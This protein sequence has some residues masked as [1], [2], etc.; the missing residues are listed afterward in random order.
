MQKL[1][2]ADSKLHKIILESIE[3][4]IQESEQEDVDGIDI[5]SIDIETLKDAYIDLRLVPSVTVYGDI[6]SDIPT[7]NEAI[8]DIQTPDTVV[9]TIRKKYQ[10][11][12]QFVAKVEVYNKIYIYI[13]TACIGINDKIIEQDMQKMGYFLGHRKQPQNVGGMLFQVLQFEPTSQMQNDETKNIKAQYD[14][15]YHW[16]PEYHLNS[17]LQNGLIPNHQNKMFDYPHRIYLMKGDSNVNVMKQL[18]QQ[19]CIV[20][21]DSRN[22]GV[23]ALLRVGLKDI[24]EDIHFYYDSNAEIGI[25][26]EQAIPKNHIELVGMY[27]FKIK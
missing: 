20:N 26:T 8:G 21:K 18:G 4:I 16:T 7:I 24:D 11:P 12:P 15:L 22:N 3:K 9:N 13:V 19:L 27:T 17:I 2:I 10:L 6:L 25:Y 1:Q 23:Y 5:S 14:Y